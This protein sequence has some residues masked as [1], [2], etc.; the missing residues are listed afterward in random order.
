MRRFEDMDIVDL[1]ELQ[2]EL[3]NRYDEF[4]AQNLNLDM[5]RGKPGAD[6]L[7]LTMEMLDCINS[8][9]RLIAEN[10][11]DCRNYGLIDGIPEAKELFSK[12]LGVT[13][14]EIIV[15][16]NSSLNIMYDTVARAMTHGVLGSELPW[17]KLPK[18]KFLC[19]VPGYDRHFS[20][21]EF[22]GIE[23]INIDMKS[24][25]PDMDA[26]EKLVS[27]DESIKGIWC[28]PKYSNP[29]GI[30]YSDEVVDRFARLK[31][32]AKD[33]RIF[34]DNAYAVHHLSD[35]HDEL[36]DI[37]AAC[38][39][40]G[41][42]NMVFIFASTSKI[43]FPGAGVAMIASSKE[44]IDFIKKQMFFQT[45]G[46]DKINQLMHVR[47]FKTVE[48]IE[49]HMKKHAKILKPKFDT[50][51]S[52]LDAELGGK[53]IAWWNKPNGGYFISL[54]TMDGCAKEVVAM[55]KEAGV[56]LTK[57]GATY[58]YGKDPHDRNIRIAP[59]YPTLEELKKAIE[60]LCICVQLVSIKKILKSRTHKL[61]LL[62]VGS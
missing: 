12:M 4:K 39:E 1:Q 43:S 9:S 52:I 44:N 30:T 31:P 5:S 54:D 58:P 53:D 25:G 26:I 61:H 62:K 11:I 28:V 57:A 21:C 14:E 50:V 49:E 19:P 10:G 47:Y 8:E 34:W 15:G 22:F 6:Q 45:I 18:V 17:G 33:F 35:K 20:I 59:T 51:L 3:Q 7:D 48:G 24:D 13:T 55:A 60:I 41:N 29:Q 38:K 16:G 27:S 40:A 56:T 23:M 46:P 42:P 32:K 37:L 2:I 36:K